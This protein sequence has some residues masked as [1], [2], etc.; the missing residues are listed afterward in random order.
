MLILSS[1][2]ISLGFY[3]L[4]WA[5]S[6]LIRLP[7]QISKHFVL[8]LFGIFKNINAYIDAV[9][10]STEEPKGDMQVQPVQ[11]QN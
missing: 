8:V 10:N 1:I 6:H 3:Y 7:N 2:F 5:L 9:T 4:I 11:S